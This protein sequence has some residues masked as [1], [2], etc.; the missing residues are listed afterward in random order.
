MENHMYKTEQ[1]VT[2]AMSKLTPLIGPFILTSIALVLA[3][4]IGAYL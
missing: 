2:E 4:I 3:L 1:K